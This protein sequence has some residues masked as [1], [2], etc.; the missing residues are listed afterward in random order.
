MTGE[1]RLWRAHNAI[2]VCDGDTG[3]DTRIAH[4]CTRAAH[5]ARLDAR[6]TATASQTSGSTSNPKCEEPTSICFAL[7]VTRSTHAF[8][9]T[10]RSLRL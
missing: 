7:G 9:F 1:A 5:V 10:T 8:Q 4:G 2:A 6:A 3:A